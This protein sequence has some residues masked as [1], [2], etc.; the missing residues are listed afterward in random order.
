MSE[1]LRRLLIAAILPFVLAAVTTAVGA[2]WLGAR[3][4][5][6]LL[7]LAQTFG[8]LAA[9][10]TVLGLPTWP[11]MARDKIAYVA[12][13]GLLLGVLL[14][15]LPRW[16]DALQV[17]ILAW[18][19]AIVGWL[20]APLGLSASTMMIA[21]ALA[22]LGVAMIGPLA[23]GRQKS[24]R[25]VLMLQTALLG[26]AAIAVLGPAPALA[27]LA[28]ALA[29]SLAGALTGGC[30]LEVA[31]AALVGPTGRRWRPPEPSRCTAAPAG[32]R[33]WCWHWCSPPTGSRGVLPRAAT[34]GSRPCC[35]RPAAWSP[36]VSP[37]RSP[38]W[39]QGRCVC[40]DRPPARGALARAIPVARWSTLSGFGPGTDSH[41]RMNPPKIR[42]TKRSL[43]V[44]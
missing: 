9:Y 19:V 41:G 14:P 18:P 13:F 39:P 43:T 23:G 1:A 26:L 30:L 7:G 6:P 20:A 37:W 32:R 16:A 33:F 35:S 11:P 34:A 24:P 3:R 22:L 44:G 29:A 38:G 8:F 27:E 28:L 15:L 42:F 25:R 36:S 2:L 17:A 40:H 10:G 21:A 12:A 31:N 4:R 5:L